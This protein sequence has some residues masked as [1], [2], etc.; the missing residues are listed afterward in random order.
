MQ[1]FIDNRAFL[2][3]ARLRLPVLAVGGQKSFG[4]MTAPVMR[5]AAGDVTESIVADS[6]HWI[7]EENPQ[8]TIRLVRG[9]IVR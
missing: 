2:A 1:T 6:G 9:L 5:A 3:G 4:P 7:M 8:A